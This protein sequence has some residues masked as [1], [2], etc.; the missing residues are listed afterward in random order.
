MYI[1]LYNILAFFYFCDILRIQISVKILI[2]KQSSIKTIPPTISYLL[3]YLQFSCFQNTQNHHY[4][5]Q[6]RVHN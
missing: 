5:Q 6:K 4:V 2:F 3:N 1:K